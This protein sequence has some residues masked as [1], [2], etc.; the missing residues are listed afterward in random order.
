MVDPKIAGVVWNLS[1]SGLRLLLL[2]LIVVA[3]RSRAMTAVCALMIAGEL[4]VSGC[5]IAYLYSPWP[6]IPGQSCT[7]RLDL[8]LGVMGAVLGLVLVLAIVRRR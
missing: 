4:V 2:L 8:P 3:F 6:T 7:A 1:G 5:S